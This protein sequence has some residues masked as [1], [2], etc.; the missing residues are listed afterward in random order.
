MGIRLHSK[1]FYKSIFRLD[2]GVNLQDA[3]QYGLSFG[4]GQ[5]F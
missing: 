4:F 5:F 1:F 2:F 3:K